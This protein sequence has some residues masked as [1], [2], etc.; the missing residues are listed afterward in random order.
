MIIDEMPYFMENR[1]WYWTIPGKTG[2]KLTDKAPEEAK[3]SY[4][5]FYERLRNSHRH[6][7]PIVVTDEEIE[8]EINALLIALKENN[9]ELKEKT[10]CKKTQK[11]AKKKES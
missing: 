11:Q 9:I 3:T 7:K 10:K 2:Y 1:E 5:E 8:A 6:T 4:K